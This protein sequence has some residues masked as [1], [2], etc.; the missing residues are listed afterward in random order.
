MLR[1]VRLSVLSETALGD[2]RIGNLI[3]HSWPVQTAGAAFIAALVGLGVQFLTN[4]K[5]IAWRAY[6]DKPINLQPAQARSMSKRLTFKVY[7]ED[8]DQ[9]DSRRISEVELPWLVLLRVR[10]SGFVPIHGKDFNTPLTFIFPGREVR[11]V[12]VIDHSGDSADKILPAPKRQSLEQHPSPR[13]L[14]LAQRLRVLVTGVSTEVPGSAEHTRKRGTYKA[15]VAHIKLSDGFLL[16]RKDRFTLRVVLNGTPDQSRKPIEH[17]GKIAAGRIVPEPPRLGPSNR[18]LLFGVVTT[19][20]LAGLLI[21]L[22]SAP[23]TGPGSSPCTGGPLLLEGSTAVAPAALQIVRQYENTCHSAH[24]T[25]GGNSAVTGSISG[26]NALVSTGQLHP[27]EAASQIAMSDGAAPKGA[28][29]SRLHGTPVGVIIFAVVVNRQ[30]GIYNLTTA[31][32]RKIF[33]GAITNWQQLGGADLPVGIVSRDSGSGTRRSFDRYVL[34]GAPEPDASSFDCTDKNE[35]PA[36]P[37][38]LCDEPSTPDLLQAVAQVPGAI[39]YAETSDVET[40]SGGKVQPVELNGVQDTF[41][42]IGTG[43]SNYQFWT[44]EYLY[45]YDTPPSRSLASEF[46]A[47]INTFTA[48]D[49]L[50]AQGYT[51]CVDRQQDLESTLCAPGA[52]L[53][54]TRRGGADKH[55]PS[56]GIKGVLA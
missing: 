40:Y 12:D 17:L 45:T 52:R 26:L 37:V 47:Y 29:Y 19:L 50:R 16:N 36:S 31:E 33:S 30:T 35:I 54:V 32:I 3:L 1:G 20:S 2:G 21:G 27:A 49:L 6:V 10:N 7:V 15:H 43:P 44:V 4:R 55:H 22:F 18:S 25:V 24:I 9:G 56:F 38:I 53:R 41:G 34:G 48:K 13:P 14:S 46:L 28:H 51:P 8:L 11:A 42:E 39:G 23:G 5:R